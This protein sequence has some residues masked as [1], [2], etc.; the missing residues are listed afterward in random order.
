MTENTDLEYCFN[1]WALVD[2]PHGVIAHTAVRAY[3]L[4][5]DDEQ[6]VAQ[7]KAL[8]S[9]D[10]HLA[11]VVPLPEEYVLVFEGG[12]KLPG[13]TTPQGFDDQL[14]LKVIDQYWEYQTTTVDALTQRENPPQ[15]PESPLNVVTFIGRTPDGQLKVIK[16]DDLD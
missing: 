3:A 16:A 7:L 10:Y 1:V 8:A 6:K 2:L 11:E 12:E 14:V 15:I 9:T 4:A 5:G 13:A